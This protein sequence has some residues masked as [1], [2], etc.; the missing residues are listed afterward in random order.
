ME[1]RRDKTEKEV[2]ELEIRPRSAKRVMTQEIVMHTNKD[3]DR[4]TKN[5][6]MWK[7]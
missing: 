5:T 4:K 2:A 6:V 3:I 7:L 1:Y